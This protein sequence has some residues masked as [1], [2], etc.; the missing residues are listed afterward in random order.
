MFCKVLL[1]APTA[2]R[3]AIEHSSQTINNVQS[4]NDLKFY[5]LYKDVNFVVCFAKSPSIVCLDIYA[6]T[7]WPQDTNL[8]EKK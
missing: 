4:D 8:I 2:F 3:C 1:S 5:D 6:I 7:T